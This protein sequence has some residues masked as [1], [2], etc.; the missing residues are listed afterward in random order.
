MYS[1]YTVLVRKFARRYAY[2]ILGPNN[3]LKNGKNRGVRRKYFLYFYMYNTIFICIIQNILGTE[4][5]DL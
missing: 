5:I 1:T 3:L 4:I 2:G